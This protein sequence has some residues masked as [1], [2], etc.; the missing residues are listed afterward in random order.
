MFKAVR[1]TGYNSDIAIDD[2]TL[3]PGNCTSPSE[4]FYV[5]LLFVRPRQI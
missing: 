3:L 5:F 4:Y 1:G 2:G